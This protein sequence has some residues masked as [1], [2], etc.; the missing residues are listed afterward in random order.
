MTFEWSLVQDNPKLLDDN[1]EVPKPNRVVGGLI[2]G[3]TIISL[4]DG[5]LPVVRW[6]NTSCVSKKEKKKL[7]GQIKQID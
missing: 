3:H 5:K 2:P 1:G 7:N 4:L 6:S